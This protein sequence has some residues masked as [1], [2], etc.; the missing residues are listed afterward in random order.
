MKVFFVESGVGK[1]NKYTYRT[2][3]TMM[4]KFGVHVVQ[5]VDESELVLVSMDDPDD[6]PSLRRARRVAKERPLIAG[7]FEC[8]CGEYLLAYA[9]AC[10]V[11]EG[12]EFFAALGRAK[13]VDE[14]YD[15]PCVLTKKKRRVVPSIRI[16]AGKLPLVRVGKRL[17]YYLAGRGCKAKCAFCLTSFAQPHWGNFDYL[18]R[19]AEAHVSRA[20]GKITLISND[21]GEI[22]RAPKIR[23]VQSVRVIDYLK[24]PQ[25]YRNANMVHFGIEGFSEKH[26]RYYSKPISDNDLFSLI[27]HLQQRK[28]P[29]AEF[30]FIPGL[31]GTFEAMMEFAEFVPACAQVY[32]RIFIKLTG[33]NPMPH[34]PLWTLGIDDLELLTDE[35]IAEFRRVLKSRNVGFRLF[36]VRARSRELWRAAVRNC[37]PDE[38]ARLGSQPNAKMPVDVFLRHLDDSDLFHLLR[39]DGRPMPNSQIVTPWRKLRDKM[40]DRRGLRSVNYKVSIDV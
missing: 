7:G 16:D 2:L 3:Y 38:T 37:S 5:S 35:Q 36:P 28:K 23:N 9:D 12:F 29:E 22:A 13:S 1:R 32:P 21:S 8:F 15:L 14:L 11:G 33:L 6:L 26:R 31:P 17:W 18:I 30:F 24:S 19:H 10:N 34:T 20:G 39:Y 40:A 27:A 25:L 4:D